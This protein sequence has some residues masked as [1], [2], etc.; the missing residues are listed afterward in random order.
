MIL[1]SHVGKRQLCPK[2]NCQD[3]G[4]EGT[5]NAPG[6][7]WVAVDHGTACTADTEHVL[8]R[9]WEKTLCSA[10]LPVTLYLRLESVTHLTQDAFSLSV[11][12]PAAFFFLF[13]PFP[14]PT[15][16]HFQ[17]SKLPGHTRLPSASLFHQ[18]GIPIHLSR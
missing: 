13:S 1:G 11:K 6:F 9:L 8:G 16:S 12:T 3:L 15:L 5:K 10:E 2:W 7:A 17:T 4:R 18:P 14:S